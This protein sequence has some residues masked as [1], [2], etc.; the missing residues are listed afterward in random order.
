M[1]IAIERQRLAGTGLIVRAHRQHQPAIGQPAD[2]YFVA[3]ETVVRR[4]IE[5][6]GDRPRF[7]L[8]SRAQYLDPA[9]ICRV[10]EAFVGTPIAVGKPFD[11]QQ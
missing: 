8:V 11:R 7:S 9:M 3:A 4:W 1:L 5:F 6:L 10:A 2:A